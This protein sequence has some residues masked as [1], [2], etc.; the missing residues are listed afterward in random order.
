MQTKK[1][2][3]NLRKRNSAHRLM[4]KAR[5]VKVAKATPAHPRLRPAR[6]NQ[7]TGVHHSQVKAKPE[8]AGALSRVLHL[9][10]KHPVYSLLGAST[11]GAA[12][13][14]FIRSRK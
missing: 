10:K 6:R 7:G 8:P 3:S 12:L 1:I 2:S 14:Y 4:M 5:Q 11:L 9:V 13:G